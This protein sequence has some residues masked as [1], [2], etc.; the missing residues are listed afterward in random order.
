L[1]RLIEIGLQYGGALCLEFGGSGSILLRLLLA[2]LAGSGNVL[3]V[4][5]SSA[6]SIGGSLQDGAYP[7][8][9]R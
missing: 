4:A 9:S 6:L 2:L 1:R 7:L 3:L 5:G 8:R